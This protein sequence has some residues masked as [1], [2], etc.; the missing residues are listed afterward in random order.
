MAVALCSLFARD[1]RGKIDEADLKPNLIEFLGG[2][3][4]GV[5][6]SEA[7]LRGFFESAATL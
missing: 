5:P 7:R 2:N 3:G 1:D 6:S 4:G